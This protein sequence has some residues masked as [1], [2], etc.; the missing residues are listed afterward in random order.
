[1]RTSVTGERSRRGPRSSRIPR[2]CRRCRRRC[3]R[4]CRRGRMM[5][6]G[7]ADLL[8][9]D[10]GLL[11][12]VGHARLGHVEAD[13]E[14]RVLEGETVLALLDRVGLRPDHAHA[15]LL[16]DAAAVE[17]HRGV[18]RGLASEG[19]E[20]D[21][22]T[23]LDDDLFDDLGGDRL[24]VGAVGELRIGHDRGR[25]RVH[26]HDLVAFLL[27]RLAGLHSGIVEFTALSDHDGT[28][29][30]QKNLV[31]R[32]ITGHAGSRV[33]FVTPCMSAGIRKQETGLLSPAGVVPGRL[34]EI[35]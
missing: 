12:R 4:G 20:E 31:N 33:K 30:D 8:A 11:H 21:V 10:V 24:D 25:I 23:F 15:V 18:Q 7:T 22:G 14:H 34:P 1:M 26:Q 32:G 28:G 17:L 5:R 9:D 2:G 19:G 35:R 13:L 29:A 16:E 3:R 6:G 27:Q